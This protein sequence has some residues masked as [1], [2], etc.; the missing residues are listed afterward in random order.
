[1]DFPEPIVPKKNL[2]VDIHPIVRRRTGEPTPTIGQRM[3]VQ[4]HLE[5]PTGF[6][7][8]VGRPVW[9]EAR[10]PFE[11]RAL[12][13]S[14]LW[15]GVGMPPGN[16]RPVLVFPG[17]LA[18]RR[19]TAALDHVLRA[20]GW[21]CEVAPVGRNAGPAQHSI[22]KA[23][24]TLRSLH[25]E[26]GER[27]RIIGHSRGGQF[28]RILAVLYPEEVLQVIGVGTPL[29]VKY[30]SYLVVKIPAETLDRLW[31]KGAFGPVDTMREQGVD[32]LRYVEFPDEVD[33]V[34]VWS[35]SDGIVD[36]RL[37]LEPAATNVEVKAS[38]MGL[39]N[40]VSGLQGIAT[41]LARVP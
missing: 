39:I 15:R 10:S 3:P 12:R 6:T 40:S 37:S 41:A 34:S 21:R 20:A 5:P 30:P 32:D 19:S 1:M 2:S 23:R 35:R 33:L 9:L 31:R 4:D 25:D 17:F 18:S 36:W 8:M 7:G 11:L 24:E 26:T 16:G 28:G 27:V 14:A 13:R 29:I 38:H 22:D